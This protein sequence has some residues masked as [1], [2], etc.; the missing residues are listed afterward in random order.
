MDKSYMINPVQFQSDID[1]IGK[2][3]MVRQFGRFFVQ[4]VEDGFTPIYNQERFKNNF[5]HFEIDAKS[6]KTIREELAESC[7]LSEWIYYKH[8]CYVENEI[9]SIN[10]FLK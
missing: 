4:S 2:R 5:K 7:C 3:R 1:Y 10:E 6:K 9:K 8:D